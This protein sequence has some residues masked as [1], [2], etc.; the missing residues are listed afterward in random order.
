MISNFLKNNCNLYL[1]RNLFL[2]T[3]KSF[4]SKIN[5]KNKFNNNNKEQL[6]Q[7]KKVSYIE[8]FKF[9]KPYY[10][11]NKAKS[12]LLKSFGITLL[13]RGIDNLSPIFLK[14]GINN[15]II[16][17]PSDKKINITYSINYI[18]LSYV[19]RMISK[20]LGQY[21][22]LKLDLLNNEITAK[23]GNESLDY[24][25]SIPYLDFKNNAEE[26]ISQTSKTYERL[27]KFNRIII[28][29]LMSNI[30]EII[31]VSLSM[32]KLLGKKY[33]FS[34]LGA[35][36]TYIIYSKQLSKYRNKL[37]NKLNYWEIK[38]ENKIYDI[39]N[40]ME[41]IKAF[42]GE[43]K[44]KK[45]YNTILSHIKEQSTKIHKSLSYLNSGQNIIMNTCLMINILNCIKEV[46]KG[47]M[48]P[49]DIFMLQGFFN[50]MMLPL[51][52]MGFLMREIERCRVQLRHAIEL[53]KNYEKM[54][55]LETKENR[56]IEIKRG[57]IELRGVS[58]SYGK[59]D[60]KELLNNLSIEFEPNKLNCIVGESGEGKS[61]I[62]ELILKLIKPI[63]GKIYIDGV[64][65]SSI[66]EKSLR[67]Y[68]TFCPQN[69]SLFNDSFLYNLLY[70]L[71]KYDSDNSEKLIH[72]LKKLN[73]Y[74]KIYSLGEGINTY[75]GSLGNKLSG[76]EKQR[77]LLIRAL[78][79]PNTKII[80]LD[81]PTSNLD[82]KNS[83][84][85]F[86]LIKKEL[87]NKTVLY[88]SH[89]ISSIKMADKIFVLNDGKIVEQGKFDDLMNKK[90][91][92]HRLM[93][94]NK[95][96]NEQFKRK[97]L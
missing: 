1:N 5:C 3:N 80:L 12:I 49:G 85:V 52:I 59:E 93:I 53:K 24:I 50:Q 75:V 70:G 65:I 17:G 57:K 33:L 78:M 69:G 11:S 72:L 81:E 15:L 30:T 2:F 74:Q 45:L 51:N 37:Y 63:K 10:S 20:I 64:D 94:G 9:L 79:K 48:T 56:D 6:N 83:G 87:Q 8:M 71:K 13:S 58:F 27:D 86:D 38:G 36:L 61:T 54:K 88:T 22:N 43:H 21:R 18:I 55:K 60:K 16:T 47:R 31:F 41:T 84:I 29:N 4:F 42:Q 95:C 39:V 62:F 73:L 19:S 89:K 35:Y 90:G 14:N 23:Y 91:F 77:I 44:E 25:N 92:L 7:Y 76:G 40:N 32:T 97:L 46:G 68:I 67:K 82:I 34:T 26:I 96:D 66:N 28:G